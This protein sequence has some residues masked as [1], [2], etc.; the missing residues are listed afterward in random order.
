MVIRIIGS[1]II[2]L[3]VIAMIVDVLKYRSYS[4][5]LEYYLMKV[6]GFGDEQESYRKLNE[7]LYMQQTEGEDE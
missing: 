7:W 6:L 3:A 2:V 5:M 1:V 4:E